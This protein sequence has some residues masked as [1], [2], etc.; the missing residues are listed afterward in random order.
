MKNATSKKDINRPAKTMISR[1]NINFS[2]Q[3]LTK[4]IEREIDDELK[5]IDISS[6]KSPLKPGIKNEY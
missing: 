5:K 6:N 2:S 1:K 4:S 3:I